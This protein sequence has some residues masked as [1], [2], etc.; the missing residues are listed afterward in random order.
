MQIK[1]EGNKLREEREK[2]KSW[3]KKEEAGRRNACLNMIREPFSEHPRSN[4]ACR[5]KLF[6][7]V[8]LTDTHTYSTGKCATVQD[9]Y[10]LVYSI[11]PKFMLLGSIVVPFSSHLSRDMLLGSAATHTVIIRSKE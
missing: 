4:H 1:Q 10:T 5:V 6:L 7:Y 9:G 2:V 8:D 3:K 11:G